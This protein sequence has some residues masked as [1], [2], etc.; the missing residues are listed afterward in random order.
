M[1]EGSMT[2]LIT[3]FLEDGSLDVAGLEKLVDFQVKNGTDA[4]IACGTTGESA[5]L[6]HEEHLKVLEIVKKKTKGTT[7][8]VIFGASS[9]DTR[10]AV[11]AT[12]EAKEHGAD[13]V[14]SLS[15]YY[16]KPTQEGIFRHYQEIA[17]VGIPIVVYNVPGRTGSNIEAATT[18]RL[19]KVPNIVAVKEASGDIT[20]I[21]NIIKG[22]PPGFKVL[23]GDD[24]L[25]Y[26]MMTMGAHGLI[27]VASNIAPKEMAEMVHA[28]QKKDYD[29]ALKIHF[30]FLPLFKNL[31]IE[32][33]PQPVKEAAKMMGLPSGTFRLPLIEMKPENRDKLRATLV[34]VGL[35]K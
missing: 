31:F 1:F 23:S 11:E 10:K 14:L 20:Q 16:N 4:I 32:T 26:N 18:L 2:A 13:G 34:E 7:V 15:P 25:T 33:N 28:L 9:N 35:L 6:S 30:R 27:S 5:T 21:A 22:A 12:R 29:T 24:G 8:K 19:A 17:K 3:P